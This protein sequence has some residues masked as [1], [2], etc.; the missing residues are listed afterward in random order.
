MFPPIRRGAVYSYHGFM[1]RH[2]NQTEARC[3]I[4]DEEYKVKFAMR[5]R[6][7]DPLN[8]FYTSD[9]AHDALPE[10]IET[11]V[12]R[13]TSGW[14]QAADDG[15]AIVGSLKISVTPLHGPEGRHIGVFVRQAV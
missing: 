14:G 5:P 7:E 1:E 11:V 4:L 3:Y 6:P 2:L 8:A 15:A 9:S 12:R 10:K 13:L